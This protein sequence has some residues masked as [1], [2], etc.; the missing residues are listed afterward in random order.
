MKYKL[1]LDLIGFRKVLKRKDGVKI[2]SVPKESNVEGG[3]NVGIFK[4]IKKEEIKDG[5]E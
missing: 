5:R 1:T 4:I 3:E 2:V